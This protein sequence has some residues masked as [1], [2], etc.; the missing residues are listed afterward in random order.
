MCVTH[1]DQRGE[2]GPA[3]PCTVRIG[4]LTEIRE[5]S[6]LVRNA[7]LVFTWR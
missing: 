2:V 4:F 1:R 7:M 3:V 5:N 6:E